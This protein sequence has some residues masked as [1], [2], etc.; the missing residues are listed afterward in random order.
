MMVEPVH[1]MERCKLNRLAA[2]P[3]RSA[4][5]Q[6]RF[7]QTVDRLAQGGQ[8]STD[9]DIGVSSIPKPESNPRPSDSYLPIS[10]KAN[11][12]SETLLEQGIEVLVS[13]LGRVLQ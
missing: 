10:Q 2:P 13:R 1:P 8:N 3:R 11:G 6:F 5:D 7:V 12:L 4:V 9:V